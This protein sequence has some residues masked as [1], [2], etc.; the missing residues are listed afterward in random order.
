VIAGLL[1][2]WLSGCFSLP[3]WLGQGNAIV[4]LGVSDIVIW[5]SMQRVKDKIHALLYCAPG[6]VTQPVQA[7]MKTL[8]DLMEVRRLCIRHA[9]YKMFV[10]VTVAAYRTLIFCTEP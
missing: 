4:A 8:A 10:D 2:V 6:T 3:G 9:G 7:Q 1:V 5:I